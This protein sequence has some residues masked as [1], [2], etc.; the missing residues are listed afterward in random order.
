MNAVG[1]MDQLDLVKKD[2]HKVLNIAAFSAG[3]RHQD[4]DPKMDE[5]AAWTIGSLV[6][7]KVLAKAG[8]FAFLAKFLKFILIALA[9]GGAW[10]ARLFKRK[11][12]EEQLAYEPVSPAGNEPNV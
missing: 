6:A 5:V 7:G 1:N 2:I 9:A 4:F 12:P 3:N 11:K 10:V 8:A